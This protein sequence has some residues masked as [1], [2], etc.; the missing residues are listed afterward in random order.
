MIKRTSVRSASTTTAF[1]VVSG[2]LA[3]A[4]LFPLI[5][6]IINSLKSPAEANQA[7]PTLFPKSLSLGNFQTLMDYGSGLPV[8]F[9]N[10]VL[11]SLLT[12]VGTVVVCVLGGY[13]FARFDFFGKKHLFLAVVAILM[14][15]Y[16]TI[17][18]PLYILLGKL[19]LAELALGA[20]PRAGH[21]PAA[22]RHADDA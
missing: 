7:P 15:P 19:G 3:I 10:S 14:V 1:H 6:A 11:V 12:V 13:G 16:A 21:V 5:W 17:L 20:Q 4:F 22:V 8:Y 9:W 2:V 18:L